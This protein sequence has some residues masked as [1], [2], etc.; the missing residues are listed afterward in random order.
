MT[1]KRTFIVSISASII[2]A[3]LSSSL[4]GYFSIRADMLERE[5][6]NLQNV[7]NETLYKIDQ[8]YES[9]KNELNTLA[10][11]EYITISFEY[12]MYDQANYLLASF[13]KNFIYY[14]EISLLDKAGKIMA[15]SE[16]SRIGSVVDIAEKQ[17]DNAT[18]SN[19]YRDKASASFLVDF[20]VPLFRNQNL[21]GFA[22][23]RYNLENLFQI[24]DQSGEEND[25]VVTDGNGGC[26]YRPKSERADQTFFNEDLRNRGM[27]SLRQALAGNTGF[28]FERDEHDSEVI[29]GYGFS[30]GGSGFS[31]I[32]VRSVSEILDNLGRLV[33]WLAVTVAVLITAGVVIALILGRKTVA[34][35]IETADML[36][37]I[38]EGEGDLTKRLAIGSDNEIGNLARHFNIFVTK[39]QAIIT[40]VMAKAETLASSSHTMSSTSQAMAANANAM[41][42]QLNTMATRT[43]HLSANITNVAIAAEEMSILVSTVASSVEEMN[44]SLAEVA[45]SAANS[46][47]I[48]MDADRQSTQANE[49]MKHLHGS[50][51]EITKILDTINDIADQTNLL[52]L[53]ATIEA[54]SAGHA[55]KGFNVVANEIKELAK[56]TARATQEISQQNKKMQNNTHN[57]VAAI[58]KIVR[59]ATEMSRLSQTIASAVEDQAKT[60]SE[61][62]ANIGNASSAARTIAGNIQQASMGAVE[63]AG[64]IQEVNEASF[65][66]ASGA[67]ETNSHA[68]ELSQ[69]ASELRELLGQFKL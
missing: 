8:I 59:V 42:T 27:S 5:G 29:T 62:S 14:Q 19:P 57:A 50:T 56:Q 65:K 3:V 37:D 24:L 45:G 10:S 52:A 49:I 47:Q 12:Q 20:T 18:I 22:F 30:K 41:S 31:A 15:S 43:D 46:S 36:K 13:G 68:E 58:E 2:A 38:S 23:A 40:N 28:V 69:M 60:I 17:L 66:S 6:H 11:M 25:V 61:I 26:I 35:I 44:V 32:A 67:G 51:Q 21:V 53:N 55:G 33:K 4:I 9:R 1:L 7:A 34:P 54:A 63:V 39:I 16:N 48:A 64:K